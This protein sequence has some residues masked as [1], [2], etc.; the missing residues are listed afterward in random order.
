[1]TAS[2]DNTQPVHVLIVQIEEESGSEVE[3]G[4]FDL[5]PGE[6]ADVTVTPGTN[7]QDFVH[8]S[9]LHGSVEVTLAGIT[10]TVGEGEPVTIAADLT[11]PTVTLTSP[12]S[13]KTNHSPIPVNVVFSEPVAGFDPTKLVISNAAVTAFAGSGAVYSFA[14]VPNSQGT[15]TVA[16]PGSVFTDFSAN[17]NIAST[18]LSRIYD[19]TAPAVT[20]PAGITLDAT[21]P[22]GAVVVYAASATDLV[23]GAVPVSCSKTSGTTFPIGV[24]TV[25]CTASDAAGNTA[26]GT[27]QVLVQAA[28]AQVRNLVALVQGF[29]L[30]QGIENSLDAKLQ[31]VLAALNAA[32]GGNATG[33]CG[34]LGAF[35]NETSAQSGKKL[36]VAQAN[37]LIAAAQQIR[38]V[39]GCN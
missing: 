13:P 15:V 27:F 28:A 38:A 22:A 11:P 25:T 14:L 5:D 20:V 19:T 4:S 26:S 21:S 39:I 2:P 1:M 6:S 16:I 33:A 36:T 34:M 18:V 8:F 17:L 35:I 37:Q 30:H 24:T 3:V 9:A 31:N 29:N 10:Q 32:Q 12:S 7:R 23:D